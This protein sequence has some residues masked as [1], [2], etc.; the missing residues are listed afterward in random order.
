M[1][2]KAF[3]TN[4]IPSKIRQHFLK[5]QE[6]GETIKSY[7]RKTGVS[8]QTF[9]SWRKRYKN[10]LQKSPTKVIKSKNQVSFASLGTLQT[11]L[12]SQKL[13]DI[14]FPGGTEVSVY[15]G[16]SAEEIAP[17]LALISEGTVKC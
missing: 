4:Q 10:E 7:C 13:L 9:Y 12:P 8:V 1:N 3:Q 15:R 2:K 11:H 6:S 16:T 17:F 14:Q 5:H